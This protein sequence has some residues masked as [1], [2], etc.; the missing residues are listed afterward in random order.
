MKRFLY[1][2]LL[3]AACSPATPKVDQALPTSTP[4]PLVAATP[5]P[6]APETP[7]EEDTGPPLPILHFRPQ[8]NPREGL[9]KAKDLPGYAKVAALKDNPVPWEPNSV[10]EGQLLY[11]AHCASCHCWDGDGDGPASVGMKPMPRNFGKLKEYRFGTGALATFRTARYGIPNSQML[12]AP[13]ELTDDQIWKIVHFVSML[14]PQDKPREV[15]IDLQPKPSTCVLGGVYDGEVTEKDTYAWTQG[16][17]T[18]FSFKLAPRKEP[19]TISVR[20]HRVTA[21]PNVKV[22]AELNG[23]KL[24][25]VNWTLPDFN[26]EHFPVPPGLLKTG[27][28]KLV[29]KYSPVVPLAEGDSRKSSLCLDYVWV[30]PDSH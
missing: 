12:P 7:V 20:A 24:A 30:A 4:T 16:P 23:R 11:R 5:T 22:T 19:Y 17:S 14:Q 13:A 9:E 28:N 10:M 27:E 18:T 1:A 25:T 26:V 6:A 29:L 8:G 3:L 15:I 2:S 21:V